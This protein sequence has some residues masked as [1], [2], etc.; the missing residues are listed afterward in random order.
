MKHLP[1]Q[2]LYLLKVYNYITVDVGLA[3]ARSREED[4]R[5]FIKD[6]DY[7]LPYGA[8]LEYLSPEKSISEI[9]TYTERNQK[10]YS[11]LKDWKN[12]EIEAIFAAVGIEDSFSLEGDF[13]LYKE[14]DNA[15]FTLPRN[16]YSL[17]RIVLENAHIAEDIILKD[18][19]W[20]ELYRSGNGFGFELFTDSLE[21]IK[22]SFDGLCAERIFL[23][24]SPLADEAKAE[25]DGV[26]SMCDAL[27]EKY[28]EDP[29]LFNESEE[30][31]LPYILFFHALSS[32]S[33][34]SICPIVCDFFSDR[35]L[36]KGRSLFEKVNTCENPKKARRL[37]LKIKKYVKSKKCAEA[38]SA[39]VKDIRNS[40][41]DKG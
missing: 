27:F 21:H 23:S 15:Y 36:K 1:D 39:L 16:A 28:S 37:A 25:T 3:S 24:V 40:Q 10:T 32:G 31:L 29:A 34:D 33:I 9:I 11:L 8:I 19:I 4:I 17:H 20:A 2:L 18:V 38:V 22:L 30:K 6:A 12:R 5:A 7:L 41:G 14:G 35:G 13:C 26:F